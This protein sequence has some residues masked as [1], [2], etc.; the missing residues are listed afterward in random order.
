MRARVARETILNTSKHRLSGHQDEIRAMMFSPDG[1]LF[2][3]GG[4][5][6]LV[7]LW[8]SKTGKEIA[9]LNPSIQ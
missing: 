1:K 7:I 9:R 5:D 8:D 4:A 6:G 3:T 2:A